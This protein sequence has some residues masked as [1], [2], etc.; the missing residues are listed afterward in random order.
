MF[1]FLGTLATV[2]HSM[3]QEGKELI[4]INEDRDLRECPICFSE[5]S[6][7]YV[8]NEEKEKEIEREFV[9]PVVLNCFHYLCEHCAQT[10]E[11]EAKPCP[12]CLNP[13]RINSI[14]FELHVYNTYHPYLDRKQTQCAKCSI[15]FKRDEEVIKDA[16]PHKHMF[17]DPCLNQLIIAKGENTKCPICKSS[18]KIESDIIHE[19]NP[20]PDP[21]GDQD[22]QNRG[23]SELMNAALNNQIASVKLLIE[24]GA[25]VNAKYEGCTPLM[26]ACS[27]EI[28]KLLIEKGADVNAQA[29]DG[30]TATSGQ[31]G[32]GTALMG[33]SRGGD[34]DLVQFLLEQGANVN[35]KDK[36]G[37][38]ALLLGIAPDKIEIA[39]IL[40]EKGADVNAQNEHGYTALM[41]AIICDDMQ[42]VKLLLANNA[43]VNIQRRD[44]KTALMCAVDNGNPKIVK[45]LVKAHADFN[46]QDE[47]GAAALMLSES[48]QDSELL[49]K[50]INKKLIAAA[51]SGNKKS[52]KLFINSG[53][54]VNAI[55]DSIGSGDT[56]LIRASRKGEKGAV[57]LLLAKNAD[58]NAR[59]NNGDTALMLALKYNHQAVVKLLI[60]S[61]ADVNIANFCG[62]TPLLY[63]SIQGNIEAVGL[64]LVRGANVNARDNNGNTALLRAQDWQIAKLLLDAGVDVNAINNSGYTALMIASKYGNNAV[65]Y[66]L[67]RI[68][69]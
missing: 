50:Y 67:S 3:Q 35:A 14:P 12:I 57:K 19:L 55:D 40:I 16:C 34:T 1:L 36:T 46:T 37:W 33:A 9:R 63:A 11:D 69:E 45:M 13:C 21:E 39:K 20:R 23:M 48:K 22:A 59:N 43:K 32:G 41:S 10:M 47:Y 52:I 68:Q 8:I 24:K 51:G 42:L 60:N 54:D 29:A 4:E 5:Y 18:I 26:Y 17:H 25:D 31:G 6:W 65:V 61:K 53:A 7:S 64:L 66:V 62:D 56:A 49:K 2:I 44:G 38:T 27:K 58:V 28:A 30:G 15:E